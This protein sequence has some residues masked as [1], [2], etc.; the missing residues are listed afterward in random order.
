MPASVGYYLADIAALKA[1]DASIRTDGYIRAVGTK[2]AWYIFFSSASDSADDDIIVQPTSG[3]GRWFKLKALVLAGEIPD[4]SEFIDDRVN[5]L[6]ADSS[7]ITTTYNDTTNTLTLAINSNSIGDTEVSA[8]SMSTITG[9]VA[10]LAAKADTSHVHTSA[11]ISDFPEAVD[12]RVS[13]LLQQG[14]GITLTYNDS[15][16]TL[17]IAGSPVPTT[18]KSE[19][20]TVGTAST[21]N[22]VG[23]L[24]DVTVS[25]GEAT[26]TVTSPP[27][28]SIDIQN[29]TTTVGSVDTLKF[30]GSG[31]NSITVAGNVATIDISGGSSGTSA[32][33][34]INYTIVS[35]TIAAGASQTLTFNPEIGVIVR[36]ITSNFYARV[37]VYIDGTS[38]TNDLARSV[39]TELTGEHGCL[40]EAVLIPANL[41]IDLA[42]P[43]ILYKKDASTTPLSITIDNLDSSSRVFN[44]VLNTLKW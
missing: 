4:L 23:A 30:T 12:D 7:H 27:G 32:I 1:I 19:G 3:T 16:N 9:L 39:S 41:E 31:V 2:R 5:A 43:V 35:G 25:G 38:A 28:T 22:V 21:I 37:R 26:L 6:I 13:A 24:V 33:S 17:T 44:I 14:T 18:F 8:L 40:L 36:K 42:P 20:T 11:N 15:S 29:A 10:A 34:E